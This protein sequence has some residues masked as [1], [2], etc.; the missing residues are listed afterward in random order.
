MLNGLLE[1]YYIPAPVN[2]PPA[3]AVAFGIELNAG[4]VS[5]ISY[6]YVFQEAIIRR[7]VIRH[8]DGGM[9]TAPVGWHFGIYVNSCLS[10]IVENNVVNAVTPVQQVTVGAGKYFNNQTPAGNLE[11]G[12]NYSPAQYVNELTT[13]A[14]LALLQ[15]S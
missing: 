1:T 7:N 4:Q 11:Q 13:D 9:S 12:Y 3:P 14:D 8:V 15:S 5:A 10:A 6:P 2:G